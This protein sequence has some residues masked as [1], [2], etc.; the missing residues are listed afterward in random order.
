MSAHLTNDVQLAL[1][2][3][4]PEAVLQFIGDDGRVILSAAIGREDARDIGLALMNFAVD[5][6]ELIR[7]LWRGFNPEQRAEFLESCHHQP[8]AAQ[9]E[10]AR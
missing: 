4:G 9:R 7:D 1:S 8:E 2:I 6:A 10:I 3:H 5:P